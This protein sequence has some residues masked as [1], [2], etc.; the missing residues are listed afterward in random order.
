[1][2]TDHVLDVTL[3]VGRAAVTYVGVCLWR[4]VSENKACPR[5]R[6]CWKERQIDGVGGHLYS[7]L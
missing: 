5:V 6:G 1:M 7:V 3:A 2:A 4:E